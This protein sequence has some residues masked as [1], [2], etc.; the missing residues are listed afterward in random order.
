MPYRLTTGGPLV[1]GGAAQP[2]DIW[3]LLHNDAVGAA[4]FQL[5]TGVAGLCARTDTQAVEGGPANRRLHHRLWQRAQEG[6][7][8]GE[9]IPRLIGARFG[10]ISPQLDENDM[11]AAIRL[12]LN[13]AIL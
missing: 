1:E 2:P 13:D 3:G 8:L 12:R 6:I 9:G 7:A 5:G 11:S 10:T 4:G